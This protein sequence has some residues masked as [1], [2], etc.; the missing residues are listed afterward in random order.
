[1]E[2]SRRVEPFDDRNWIFELK[3]DGFR[4]VAYVADGQ[5]RLVS[6]RDN[7]YKSFDGLRAAIA[8]ELRVKDAILDGEIVCLD[9]LGRSQFKQLMF[10]RGNPFFYAFDL[11]IRIHKSNYVVI[12]IMWSPD[13][14]SASVLAC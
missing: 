7:V 13:D 14:L 3:H 8:H 12:Q 1:M 11:C 10:R 4:A 6:R 2:L 9:A 5:C